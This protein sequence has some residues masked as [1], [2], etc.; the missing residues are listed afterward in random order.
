MPDRIPY[1]YNK[2]VNA[3]ADAIEKQ[4]DAVGGTA[5]ITDKDEL[6]KED[7]RPFAAAMDE[8]KHIWG[9]I[10]DKNPT[11]SQFNKIEKILESN[12]GRPHKLSDTIESEQEFLEMAILDLKDFFDKM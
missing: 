2:F 1:D 12:F 4:A 7:T 10:M 5:F 8:A 6:I 9:L 3:L 11:D